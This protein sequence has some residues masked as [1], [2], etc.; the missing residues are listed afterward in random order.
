[1]GER[2]YAA[3]RKLY[4]ALDAAA[5]VAPAEAPRGRP[6]GAPPLPPTPRR[7]REGDERSSSSSGV[8]NDE[9]DDDDT[10]SEVLSERSYDARRRDEDK[11]VI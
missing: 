4:E 9:D 2:V 3:L 11:D 6:V 5:Q 8:S 7:R 1:M 10:I